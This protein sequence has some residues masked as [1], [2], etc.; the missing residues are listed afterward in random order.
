MDLVEI[1]N[2]NPEEEE[3]EETKKRKKRIKGSPLALA[4]LRL[5]NMILRS[6]EGTLV[7]EQV[8]K[9]RKSLK[10]AHQRTTFSQ[11][12]D[13]VCFSKRVVIKK[14]HT[15]IFTFQLTAC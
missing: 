10:S 9:V 12:Y 5:R 2:D 3:E 6:E 14:V 4:H 1:S 15:Y 8:I 7:H 11:L 13:P